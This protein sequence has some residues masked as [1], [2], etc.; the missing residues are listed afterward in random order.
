MIGNRLF[1]IISLFLE[2]KNEIVRWTRRWRLST[3]GYSKFDKIMRMSLSH[4][5]IR[6]QIQL[7]Y[8][9]NLHLNA[10]KFPVP[11]LLTS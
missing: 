11:R 4:T 5:I 7:I 2:G 9:C 3:I 6:F 10:K 1:I 8:T